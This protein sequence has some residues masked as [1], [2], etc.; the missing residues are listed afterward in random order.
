MINLSGFGNVIIMN[1]SYAISMRMT[2][3][4]I[5]SARMWKIGIV[6]V[7]ISQCDRFISP[8]PRQFLNVMFVSF[9]TQSFRSGG[10]GAINRAR[11]IRVTPALNDPTMPDKRELWWK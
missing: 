3:Y 4:R 11:A 2:I 9:L 6:I 7:S 8:R 10:R 1:I 5:I